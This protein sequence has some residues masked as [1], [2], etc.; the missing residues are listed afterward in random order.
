MTRGGRHQGVLRMASGR[1]AATICVLDEAAVASCQAHDR[2]PDHH[3]RKIRFVPSWRLPRM[4]ALAKR[5]YRASHAVTRN[6]QHRKRVLQIELAEGCLPYIV[7][8]K[9]FENARSIELI[10][11]HI[12]CGEAPKLQDVFD[13]EG[14]RAQK[15][16]YE[17]ILADTLRTGWGGVVNSKRKR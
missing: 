17:T 16:Y 13:A 8:R 5:F 14:R 1:E 7:R 4:V 3:V 9:V 10:R 12:G 6:L 15:G 2:M 11:K